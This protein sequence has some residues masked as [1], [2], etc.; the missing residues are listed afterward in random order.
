MNN[1]NRNICSNARDTIRTIYS[2]CKRRENSVI[3]KMPYILLQYLNCSVIATNT[4]VS[5]QQHAARRF[6]TSMVAA[7]WI[8]WDWQ[9]LATL[10]WNE[11]MWWLDAGWTHHYQRVLF[12]T[13]TT[14]VENGR[15]RWRRNLDDTAYWSMEWSGHRS[16]FST[17]DRKLL[18][19]HS[20]RGHD[21]LG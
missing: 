5:H 6:N 4:A 2:S 9:N 7:S 12:L 13:A 3:T 16:G 20:K 15:R 17:R 11:I 14:K 8:H 19:F 21:T 1:R 10:T 18:E